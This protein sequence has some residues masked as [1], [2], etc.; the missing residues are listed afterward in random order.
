MYSLSFRRTDCEG[1]G[2]VVFLFLSSEE[3]VGRA[4]PVVAFWFHSCFGT[5]ARTGPLTRRTLERHLPNHS[6]PP[7]YLFPR[8]LKIEV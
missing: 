3:Q 4:G 6:D 1:P 5:P 2:A 8:L 7:G